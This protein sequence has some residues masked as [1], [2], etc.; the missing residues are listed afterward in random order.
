MADRVAVTEVCGGAVLARPIPQ[1]NATKCN[2]HSLH[3]LMS[4]GVQ[5]TPSLHHQK[6]KE[7]GEKEV[8]CKC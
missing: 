2:C 7:K 6:E 4:A 3:V 8:T 5:N 1:G